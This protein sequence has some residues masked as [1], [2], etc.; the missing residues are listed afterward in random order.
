MFSGWSSRQVLIFWW[1]LFIALQQAERLFL[2]HEVWS[3]DRP[4][5]G[6]IS[7]TLWTGF[8]A[9]L[10]AAS[11]AV[12]VSLVLGSIVAVGRGFIGAGQK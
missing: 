10:I 9:D 8:R 2:V 1:G 12:L 5:V 6:L 7:Q 4:T 3:I 11:V